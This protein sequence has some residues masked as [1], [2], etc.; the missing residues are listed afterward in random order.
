VLLPAA[1]VGTIDPIAVP[2]SHG[3]FL[4]GVRYVAHI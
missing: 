3:S 1:D 2:G 4:A